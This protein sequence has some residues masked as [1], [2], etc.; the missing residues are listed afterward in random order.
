MSVVFILLQSLF[1]YH[2]VSGKFYL[3]N[4]E[5]SGD[6]DDFVAFNPTI[7]HYHNYEMLIQICKHF[8]RK[9]PDLIR[10][11]SLGKS[12]E[13]RHIIAWKLRSNVRSKRGVGVPL[14]KIVGNMHGDESV[15]REVIIALAQYLLHNYERDERVT[16]IL[17][18]TEVH[19]VPSMNPD[20]FEVVKRE[21]H[22]KVDLNRNFPG[23]LCFIVNNI[24]Y[25]I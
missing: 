21:N 23:R 13:G 18:N 12:V 17:D 6:G 14:V 2:N 8:H 15:G 22:N 20:G 5:S 4:V 24:C 9:F 3:I 19:L 25:K 1:L 10:I 11:R 7:K 16:R